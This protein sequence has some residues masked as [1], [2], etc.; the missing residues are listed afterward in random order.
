MKNFV[1]STLPI[2]CRPVLSILLKDTP[3]HSYSNLRLLASLFEQECYNWELIVL[4]DNISTP[5]RDYINYFR[6]YGIGCVKVVE[7][8]L[9]PWLYSMG[10]YRM[11]LS[12]SDWLDP[13]L[14]LAIDHIVQISSSLPSLIVFDEVELINN[15][16]CTLLNFQHDKWSIEA[17]ISKPILGAYLSSNTSLNPIPQLQPG[18]FLQSAM[19][20]RKYDVCSE[21]SFITKPDL[22]EFP[23][24]T[25]IIPTIRKCNEETN[26]PFVLLLLDAISRSSLPPQQVIVVDSLPNPDFFYQ[27]YTNLFDSFLVLNVE[28][29]DGKNF[30][31]SKKINSAFCHVINEHFLIL[32]DD[33]VPCSSF[34]LALMLMPFLKDFQGV[35]GCQLLFN[36]NI[37]QHRGVVGGNFGAV[38]HIGYNDNISCTESYE[39]YLANQ[40]RLISMV[41]GAAIATTKT[42]FKA[43][44]GLD[45]NLKVE[46]GDLD[47]CLKAQC[48][49]FE[50]LYNASAIFFHAEKASRM[51]IFPNGLI[52]EKEYFINRWKYVL[53]HDLHRHPLASRS[54]YSLAP[55]D[56]VTQWIR[57]IRRDAHWLLITVYYPIPDHI[58]SQLRIYSYWGFSILIINNTNGANS[59]R[60]PLDLVPVIVIIN[61]NNIDL[62]AGGVNCG[63]SYLLKTYPSDYTVTLL[64]QDSLIDPEGLDMLRYE[65]KNDMQLVVGPSVF[66]M[67]FSLAHQDSRVTPGWFLLS[68]GTTFHLETWKI[69]GQYET[70]LGIDYL[71]HEWCARAK[72]MNVVIR[73]VDSVVLKQQFGA[74]HPN[75]FARNFRMHFYSSLRHY[76]SLRNWF[77]L[78]R[79]PHLGLKFKVFEGLKYPIKFYFWLFC[80]SNFSNNFKAILLG[81]AH[82]LTFYK[83]SSLYI[84]RYFK[85]D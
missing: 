81:I 76:I 4:A 22:V 69:V 72:F 43:I 74:R 29:C 66:D 82:G 12:L 20:S 53:E 32:N 8:T 49:G 44:G 67:D 63:L 50:V 5:F 18:I 42:V 41:T 79:S 77:Y 58:L 48:F 24:Y 85:I 70:Y 71:D 37:L 13:K 84:Q 61:N 14:V 40:Q 56:L 36:N 60:I 75:K 73:C 26:V 2:Q 62:L 1:A 57:K 35:I 9:D 21:P 6:F 7:K 65:L 83:P 38:S 47:F 27:D 52:G 78:L 45:T 31:Y 59:L 23:S 11:E 54:S 64:D 46:Y 55:V 30:N 15:E 25:I 80:E 33:V 68:S 16:I 34:T 28:N 19:T 3:F 10:I 51:D 17:L 39:Y